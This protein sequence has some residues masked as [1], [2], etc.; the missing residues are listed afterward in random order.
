MGSNIGFSTFPANKYQAL[1][2]L[3]LESLD[4]TSITPEELVILYDETYTAIMD[5]HK[6]MRSPKR[7][8]KVY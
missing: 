6:E 2:M 3:Y 8:A 5:K 7:E 4:L 1:T